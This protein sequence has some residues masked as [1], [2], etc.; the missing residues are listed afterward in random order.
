MKTQDIVRQ[1]YTTLPALTDMFT[2]NLSISTL[3]ALN[4][5]ATAVTSSA[6]GLTTGDY[7]FISGAQ[8]TTAVSS[9]LE[10]TGIA[11]ATTA[12]DHDLTMVWNQSITVF[13]AT[14]PLYNVSHTLRSV[15][16]RRTFTF[17]IN[18]SVESPALGSI[19]M[20][21]PDRLGYNGWS[22]IT[23]LSTTSF[24]Y[25]NSF[26][27]GA[28]TATGTMS[29]RRLPRITGA[30]TVQKAVA[31]YTKYSANQLYLFAVLGRTRA[32][33]GRNSTSI[34]AYSPESE[35]IYRQ[36][37]IQQFDLYLFVPSENSYAGR[38]AR[39]LSEEIAI[40]LY[41]SILGA[42]FPT[43]LVDEPS[44]ICSFLESETYSYQNS[45]YI[46]RFGFEYISQI[47]QNDIFQS[48]ITRAFRDISL[49][50]DNIGFGVPIITN[51]FSLDDQP[52]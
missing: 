11:T 29:A 48:D 50:F 32:D 7:V 47:T 6:H 41:K 35:S 42:A 9:I 33:L 21:E 37:L 3:S 23:V 30:A 5:T 2:T 15:P 39:D 12:S 14:N 16:N 46:H 13:G 8:W 28:S 52:L 19:F 26:L 45:F 1:L 10:S 44:S 27:V 31:A 49:E 43:Y 25:Q 36:N 22:Q 40:Y 38:E 51:A 4:G 18:P 34:A 24:S 20:Q 17:E